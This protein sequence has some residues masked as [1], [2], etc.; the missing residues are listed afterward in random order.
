MPFYAFLL[1]RAMSL[2]PCSIPRRVMKLPTGMH[3]PQN[4]PAHRLRSLTYLDNAGYAQSPEDRVL[5]SVTKCLTLMPRPT[6]FERLCQVRWKEQYLE[7]DG[8]G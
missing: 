3:Y 7:C 5:F 1:T 6:C 8:R 4:Y 2:A